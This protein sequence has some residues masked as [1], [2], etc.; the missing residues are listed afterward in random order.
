MMMMMMMVMMMIMIMIILMRMK[1]MMIT[2]YR[3]DDVGDQC[4]CDQYGNDEQDIIVA[5]AVPIIVT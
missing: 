5:N 1:M 3:Y 2:L 4:D